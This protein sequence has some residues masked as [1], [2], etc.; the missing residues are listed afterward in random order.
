M[1]SELSSYAQNILATTALLWEIAYVK[2]QDSQEVT[3]SEA[4][5]GNTGMPHGDAAD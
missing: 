4:E 1:R 2:R 3:Q 5:T